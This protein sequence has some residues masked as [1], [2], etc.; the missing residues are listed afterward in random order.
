MLI[1]VRSTAITLAV[2]AFFGLSI[3]SC[4][5]GLAPFT[6]CKRAIIGAVC[7]YIVVKIGAKAINAI[8]INAMITSKEDKEKENQYW[9]W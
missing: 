3:I 1:N 4:V 2:I 9:Q 7:A 8:L 5:S 6:C